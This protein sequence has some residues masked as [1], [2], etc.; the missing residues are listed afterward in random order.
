MPFGVVEPVDAQDDLTVAGVSANRL[1]LGHDVRILR[2]RR[3]T[4]GINPYRKYSE[5]G[6]TAGDTDTIHVCLD[7][8]DVQERRDEMTHV[9]K[10]LKSHE[11]G[12][13]NAIQDL[14]PPG[15]D[16]KHFR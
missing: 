6:L 16:P 13:E 1:R 5:C 15:Q 14:A 2:K 4:F 3:E 9:G 11:I 7:A 12:A 10:C 8:F